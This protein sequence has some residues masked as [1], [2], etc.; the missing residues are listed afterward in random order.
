MGNG[1]LKWMAIHG[2]GAAAFFFILQYVALKQSLE[3]SLVWAAAGAAGAVW[4]A[5]KQTSE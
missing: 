5:R 3:T 2:A 1:S 4:I